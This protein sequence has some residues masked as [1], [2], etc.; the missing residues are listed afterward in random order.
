MKTN[1]LTGVPTEELRRLLKAI[2]RDVLEFPINRAN[3]IAT[4]FGHVEGD[5]GALI[6]LNKT[7]AQRVVVAVLAE[8]KPRP[9]PKPEEPEPQ[10]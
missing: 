8:R 2:H 4:A 9:V 3:L 10:R 1:D 6:G 5:L 7:A